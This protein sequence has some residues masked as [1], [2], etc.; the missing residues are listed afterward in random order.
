MKK[1]CVK[2]SETNGLT[3]AAETKW[4]PFSR[5]HFQTHFLN[6]NVRISTNISL[7]FVP[8]GPVE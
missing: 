2:S 5:R 4:P 7:I 8:W 3:L 1:C 6:E